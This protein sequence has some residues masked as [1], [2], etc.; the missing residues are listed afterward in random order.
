MINNLRWWD[1]GQFKIKSTSSK[2][3]ALNTWF[4]VNCGRVIILDW[5]LDANLPGALLHCCGTQ[6][7]CRASHLILAIAGHRSAHLVGGHFV[8]QT[9]VDSG[10]ETTK[11]RPHRVDRVLPHCHGGLVPNDV[12]PDTP[13]VLLEMGRHIHSPTSITL[14]RLDCASRCLSQCLMG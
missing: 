5:G 11:A 12:G 13:D 9:G 2:T 14:H 6:R 1:K 7:I 3:Q 4:F 8:V 10:R